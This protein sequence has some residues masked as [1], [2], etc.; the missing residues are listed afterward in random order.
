MSDGGTPDIQY[1][2]L[3]LDADLADSATAFVDTSFT[4][5][6]SATG[7]MSGRGCLLKFAGPDD[8]PVVF[9]VGQK[10]SANDVAFSVRHGA[11]IAVNDDNA[12]S[13]LGGQPICGYAVRTEDSQGQKAGDTVVYFAVIPNTGS[14]VYNKRL[15]IPTSSA[16]RMADFFANNDADSTTVRTFDSDVLDEIVY[17][18]LQY[19]DD[20]EN[21]RK[22]STVWMGDNRSLM[23]VSDSRDIIQFD[24]NAG[25]FELL[26]LDA[27]LVER[28][29]AIVMT[30]LAT[31]A[32]KRNLGCA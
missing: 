8:E 19:G 25:S 13:R 4:D 31:Q 14:P 1:R 7:E 15:N 3:S 26:N 17:G 23:V 20:G 22:V 27:S 5:L 10:D 21:A 18:S 32:D 9:Y 30:A 28:R 2:A 16:E 12:G 24:A 6:D 29:E 11:N